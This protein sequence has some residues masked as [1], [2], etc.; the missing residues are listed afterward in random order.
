[1]A[2]T[3]GGPPAAPIV[4][5]PTQ[6]RRA[7]NL[8]IILG[9]GGVFWGVVIAPGAIMNVFFKNELG[10]SSGSL[11]LLVAIVQMASVLNILAII[12][13]GRLPRVKPFWIIVTAVHRVL[14][15][16]PAVVALTV[17]RGG[18]KVG[19]AQAVL[20]ALAASH[21]VAN[22]G[23][24]GWW[25][26]MADVVPEDTRATFFLRRSA[27]LNAVNMVWSLVAT[28]ALSLL[29][30]AD[31][32]WAYLVLFAVGAAAGVLEPLLY[33]V[34][35][36]PAPREARPTF[37]WADLVAPLKDLNFIGFSLSIALWLFSLNV[38][39]PFV[40]PYITSPAGAGAP[41]IWL[42]IMSVI[43]QL[44]YVG[45]TT[46]W[47]VLMDRFGRKPVVLLGSLYPL[48]WVMYVFLTPHN[49]TWILPVT[50]LIQGLLSPAILDGA[51]QLMLTLT[52]ERQRTSYVAWYITIAG[53]VPSFGALL[54][55]ALSD[56]LSGF[57][58]QVAGRV[59]IGGFQVVILLCFALT[60]LSFFI[61]SRIREGREKPVGFLLSVLMTPNIFRTFLTIN[62]LGR[63]EA[64]TK[65]ARAL[66]SVE[67]GAGAIA[68]SDII[69]RLDDPDDEVREEA[70][71]ALG[72][73]GAVEAVDAL[74]RHLKD[75]HSTIRAHAARALGRIG[76]PRAAAPL[77]EALAGAGTAEDLTEACCQALGHMPAREAL[78]PLLRLL[79]EER[80][81]R[82]VVA[83]SQ[84]MSR[85][86]AYEAALE[87]L[88]RMHAADSEILQ[89]QFAI[90]MGNLL[91]T[92]G[93]F[94]PLVTGDA[95]SRSVALERLAN[96]AQKNL[97]ALA[98][99]PAARKAPAG[100]RETL[101]AAGRKLRDAVAAVDHAPVVDHLHA[102]VLALCRLLAGRDA[103][104]DDALGF[105]F[106]HNPQLGLGFW[107]ATEVKARLASLRGTALLEMDALLGM[108]FL[109]SYRD[110]VDDEE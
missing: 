29:K 97:Q 53:I 86:G 41:F 43:T 7:L 88:P 57:H 98:A 5:S 3:R 63:G 1:M 102:C 26:W 89:R 39:G 95:S 28:G 110:T 9:C 11:G 65:V 23:T 80:S 103:N 42:G 22:L 47:G 87:I 109:A 46:S 6:T 67:K 68:V 71:R 75:P 90:A 30:G 18:D 82:I 93:Q 10:A 81:P 45:T 31:V 48:S 36:E 58:V 78:K 49:Y 27:V 74:I 35:P 91:G 61:L 51:G 76:D 105:A 24:S 14:G 12:I 20:I 104:E 70:V 96:E 59:P 52:P 72:R 8:N 16:V 106:M 77:V 34:I 55:G 50:A 38:L 21:L 73:L 44:S 56:A 62:V 37:A 33:A 92:P 66:R 101:L 84:A 85:L 64:P 99:S 69:R 19:G 40:A 25:R 83:A 32:L 100:A 13:L 79:G 15:F 107:F 4:L 17:L 2:R 60:I 108:Y 94:Y 54:G